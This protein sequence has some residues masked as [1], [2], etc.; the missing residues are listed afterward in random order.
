MGHRVSTTY[1]HLPAHPPCKE[2]SAG[3]L[4]GEMSVEELLGSIDLQEIC[5][6]RCGRRATAAR[7]RTRGREEGGRGVL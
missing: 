7:G 4:P 5:W 3:H 2:M 1:L 6:T